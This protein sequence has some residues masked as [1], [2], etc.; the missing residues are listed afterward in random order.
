MTLRMKIRKG[1][2]EEAGMSSSRVALIRQRGREWVERGVTPALVLLAARRGVVVLHEAYGQ[3]RP[4]AAS[5]PVQLDS[6]FPIQSVSKTLTAT[7]AMMLVDDGL[8]GLNRPVSEYIPEF[9]GRGRDQIM[10]HHLLT[11]TWGMSPEDLTEFEASWHWKTKAALPGEDPDP[12]TAELLEI[13]CEAPIRHKPGEWQLYMG[14]GYTML[15][16]IVRRIS[17]KRIDQFAKERIF[18]PLGMKD[19]GWC[20]GETVWNRIVKRPP[21]AL[22]AEI[23][24]LERLNSPSGQSDAYST[25]A[26]LAIFGQMFLNGGYHGEE[27]ILSRPTVAEMMRDQIPGVPGRYGEE[28]FPEAGWSYGWEIALDKKWCGTLYS[29]SSIEHV[30]AGGSY[31]WIDPVYEVVG[32][33]LSVVLEERASTLYRWNPDLFT[34][35]V[36][37]AI[38]DV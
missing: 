35:M 2:P 3:L 32:V 8:V 11:H 31:I 38:E 5:P 9:T 20:P 33:Y 6:I 13:A 26:D 25:A 27:R 34:N 37:A 15:G 7:C 22:D 4:E 30:G 28:Y 18:G 1:T 24:D 19:S 17:G 16:E 10:V 12:H 14:R 29:P 36:T 21:D 23:D